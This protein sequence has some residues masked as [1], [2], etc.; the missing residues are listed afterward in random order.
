MPLGFIS[1]LADLEFGMS[2]STQPFWAG[3][4]NAGSYGP[5]ILRCISTPASIL[6]LILGV[7]G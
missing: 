3:L 2:F 7:L 6:T 4:D 1:V 5:G